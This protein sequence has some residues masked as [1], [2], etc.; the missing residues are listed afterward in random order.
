[1]KI[2]VHG[3]AYANATLHVELSDEE[4]AEIAAGLEKS[5]DELTVDDISEA[6]EEKAY[7]QVGFPGLCASC[8][9]WGRNDHSMDIG[10]FEPADNTPVEITER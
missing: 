4:L 1:M 10:D 7:Q 3:Q 5:V 8:S 9:G 2:A 6:A